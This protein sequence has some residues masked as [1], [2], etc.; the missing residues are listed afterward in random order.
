MAISPKKSNSWKTH[1]IKWIGV[2]GGGGILI[3]LFTNMDNL[4]SGN[5]QQF[6]QTSIISAI[7]WSIL[8]NGNG[9]IIDKIDKKWTWLDAPVKRTVIGILAMTAFSISASLLVLYAYI[10]F[11]FGA[12]F[13]KVAEAN[14]WFSMLAMPL[15]LTAIIA[16]WGHGR[17]FLLEWRQAAIDV[18]RLKNE[19][20]RSKFESMKSQ[21]NPHFLFNSLNAL[22]SLVYENQ[23]HAV[24]FI[25]RLSEVYRYVLDHQ[26]DEVVDL[27]EE[28]N[29]LNSYIYLNKIRFGDSLQVKFHNFSSANSEGSLPPLALQMVVENAIKHNEVSK[30]YPLYIDISKNSESINVINNLNPVVHKRSDSNG[31][32][33]KNI[34][35][36]YQYL[37]DQRVEAKNDGKQ[38]SVQLPILTF[39]P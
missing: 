8:A 13:F 38:F 39:S 1:L 5:Y 24:E 29:F 4:Q 19:N 12:D 22:S 21:I 10:T 28:L 7:F 16:L 25:Q 18:E 17:A 3:G 11:Y 6:L 35:A 37:S 31:L 23:D 36:R 30:D 14:G 26:N 15:I 34:R 33:L 20:L 9:W 2:P 27:Q 32:G